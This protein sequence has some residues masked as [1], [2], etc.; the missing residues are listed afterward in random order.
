MSYGF[1]YGPFYHTGIKADYAIN[2]K[3]G[4]MLGIAN[5]TDNINAISP[6]KVVIGQYSNKF[7]SDKTFMFINYQGGKTGDAS[8]FSQWDLVLTNAITDQV[9]IN[10]DGTLFMNKVAGKKSIW[11]SNAFYVN[12]D[13]SSK[14]GFTYRSE[15]FYDKNAISAGAFAT[16]IFANTLSLNYKIKQFILVPE[17]R[18]E[19]AKNAIYLNKDG[20]PTAKTASFLLAAIYKF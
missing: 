12:Y 16:N 3:S 8:S 19:S 13:P 6:Y 9:A 10:Y 4:F 11:K 2:S 18:F 14:I 5:P 17:L 15:F 7:F 20:D 1:S